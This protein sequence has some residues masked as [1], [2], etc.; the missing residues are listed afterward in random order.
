MFKHVVKFS[1]LTIALCSV[2]TAYATPLEF[3]V[4]ANVPANTFYVVKE[5]S[6]VDMN[7]TYDPVNGQ[8]VTNSSNGLR[9]HNSVGSIDAYLSA[10]PEMLHGNGTDSVA[11]E[12][13]VNS[14]ALGVGQANAVEVLT[15]AEA[16]TQN[17]LVVPL[18]VGS[19]DT[20]VVAGDYSGRVIMMFDAK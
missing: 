9:A 18:S 12:V 13:S 1:A 8:F 5:G 4:K 17:G 7:L 14:K 16:S 20:N 19:P 11:L 15:A 6:W 10:V 2:G 3:D